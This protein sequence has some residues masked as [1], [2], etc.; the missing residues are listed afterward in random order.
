LGTG[1]LLS[2]LLPP[3]AADGFAQVPSLESRA[4]AA[5]ADSAYYEATLTTLADLVAFRTVHVER[6]A[7]ADNPEFR[8]M[9][10][11]LERK[12]RHLGLDFADHG[13][14]VVIGL[15]QPEERLGLV[16][17]GDVQPADASKWAENPFSLDGASEPGKLVG[18]GSE[19]DKGPIA[20]ALYAM[21][22]V[23]D[24]GLVLDRRIE[25]IVSYTEE[26]DWQPFFAFLA[27]N[28]PPDLNVALDA[29]YPVVVAEKGWNSI[30]L[31]IAPV[32]GGSVESNRLIA[33]SGGAFLSQIP[34]DAEAVIADP[35]PDVETLLRA[36]ASRDSGI[37]YSFSSQGATLT[38]RA[39]GR[40][41]HSSKPED[42]R[43]AITHLAALLGTYEW[44]DGQAARMVRLINDLVGTGDYAERFG[45]VAFSHPFMGRLTL[46]LTTLGM[47]DGAL[48]A[49]INIRSPAGRSAAELEQSLRAAVEQWEERSGTVDVGVRVFTSEPYYVEEAPHIAVLLDVFE[50]FAGEP[51]PQPISIGGGTHA[52]VVPNG[53]NFGPAMPGEEYTGHTEHEYIGREQMR[54][55]LRMYTAMLVELAG[56]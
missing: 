23:R 37:R 11:Y 20:T 52:R 13:E 53:V 24:R 19:D 39:L 8:D 10:T 4:V 56:R 31:A 38:I 33:L 2:V 35:T 22:A 41:A 16:T 54:L 46:S 25:L 51:D 21:A 40:S 32:A 17:H 9:T 26:S 36:G 45:D 48:V 18:R 7:N 1:A 6:V 28:P 14:V 30:H 42:G 15:G 27:R 55:N 50:H 47:V 43:N 44:Q 3:V 12:A 5:Y 34:E 49:G 29:E